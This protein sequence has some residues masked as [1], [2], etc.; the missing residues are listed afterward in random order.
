MMMIGA[1]IGYLVILCF[2]LFLVRA[3]MSCI[4][5]FNA[6]T[7]KFAVGGAILVALGLALVWL[8]FEVAPFSV[9]FKAAA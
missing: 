4:I 9:I 8:S 7:G 2:G 5:F 6:F 1:I 3:G